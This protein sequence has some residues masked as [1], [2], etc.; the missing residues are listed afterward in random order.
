[1]WEH[2]PELILTRVF[3]RL[4]R[5]DRANAA[6]ACRHW[7]RCLDTPCLWR[8]CT[9]YV[10]Q[11]FSF[12]DTLTSE[13][14][15]KYGEYM[16]SLE[17]IWERPRRASR[18]P[19]LARSVQAELGADFLAA[20]RAQDPQLRELVL[21]NWN[22]ASKWGNSGKLLRALGDLLA[23]QPTLEK[24]NMFNANLGLSDALRLL[25]IVVRISG[26]RLA[27]LD[28]H[29]AFK[30]WKAPFNNA[31]YLRLIGRLGAL[32]YLSLDY[33]ALS[34]GALN[35]LAS[36]S[37]NTLEQLQ[38]FV[39]DSDCRQHRID[40]STWLNLVNVCPN[41]SVSYTLVNISHHEDLS[42]LLL[43]SV[44]LAKFQMYGHNVWDQSRSRN[45][46]GT[47][48]L[49]IN[50]YTNTLDEVLLQLRNNREMLD[51]LILTMLIQCKKLKRLQ[52]DG[53]MRNLE[54]I[55]DICRLTIDCRARYQTIHFKH[56]NLNPFN[57]ALLRD[58]K[59][60][61]SHK[62]KYQGVDFAIENP[63]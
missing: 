12:G 7:A 33:P 41:L 55:R 29:G 28:L 57:R 23:C 59:Q 9:V 40:D 19:R 58:I 45:F 47:V 13:L 39:K 42:Y 1:M 26:A 20:V 34:D 53:I 4:E 24:L 32:K 27:W 15:V 14:A 44:P 46:R 31:R 16:R 35:A 63:D 52:Y 49:L 54:T 43:P 10:D 56:K 22:Y 62:I 60:D 6:Q 11:D 25:A 61:M 50:H 5:R 51:D 38:V 30:D 48:G 3:G 21:A 37:P 8:R 18:E 36:G 2:L 17:L